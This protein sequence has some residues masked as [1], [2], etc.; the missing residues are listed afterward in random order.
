RLSWGSLRQ[1]AQ[2]SF[3]EPRFLGRDL[4]AGFDI[5]HYRYDLEEE[6][7]FDWQSTGV[8]ARFGW[9]I[10]NY[11]SLGLRYNLKADEIIV[12]NG[13]CPGFG[14]RALCEQ[15]GSFINSAVGYTFSVNRVNDPIR[16][17]RG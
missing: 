2:L 6:S 8:G 13:Y 1:Q 9:P 10:N 3:T 14:S 17:T 7:S 4:R 15:V 11:A 12:P 5:F 16:P